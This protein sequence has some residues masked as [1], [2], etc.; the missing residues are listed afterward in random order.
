MLSIRGDWQE[1]FL[2]APID[3]DTHFVDLLDAHLAHMPS[4]QNQPGFPG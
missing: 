1:R 3:D 2:M 4:S